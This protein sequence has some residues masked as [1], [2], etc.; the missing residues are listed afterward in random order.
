MNL[1]VGEHPIIPI[2]VIRTD[3][4]KTASIKVVEGDVQVIVPSTLSEAGINDL[5]QKKSKWI[6]QKLQL[7]E[8]IKPVRPKEFVSGESFAY[9]GKNYR[10]KLVQGD[11]TG[12]KLKGG[13]F[14]LSIPESTALGDRVEFIKAQLIQ[15]YVKHADRRLKDKSDR[16]AELVGVMHK[17]VTIKHYK[18]RWGG[19]SIDGDVYYNW[20]IIMA[21]HRVVD[22]VVVHELCHLKHHDHSRQFWKSVGSVIHDYRE[23]REWLKVCGQGL[24]IG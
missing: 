23:C 11:S 4:K 9:L 17:S 15:W 16:Y 7:Q 10:L 14:V 19:C 20:R 6:R 8:S 13:Y 12:V 21:P 24:R 22:Y 2:T 3:R 1:S 18:S 5:V